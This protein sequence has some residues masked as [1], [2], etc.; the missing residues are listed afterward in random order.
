MKLTNEDKQKITFWIIMIVL[1]VMIGILSGCK[2]QLIY[3]PV[4]SVKT[5]YQDRIQRDS[6]HLYDSIFVK[7]KSD[8]V[9]Y[10]KYKYLYHL[11][12]NGHPGMISV[13]DLYT[14]MFL[15]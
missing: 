12:L 10:E 5:E 1:M 15:R 14:Q 13:P 6:I 3:V 4:E 9:F 8:T 11:F 2:P 7:M